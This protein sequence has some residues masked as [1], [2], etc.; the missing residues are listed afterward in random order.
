M[1]KGVMVLVLLLTLFSSML[2]PL[3]LAGVEV[4]EDNLKLHSREDS[5]QL[6]DAKGLR[7]YFANY[8][9]VVLVTGDVIHLYTLANGSSR[10][11]VEPVDPSKTGK[12]FKVFEYRDGLYVIPSDITLDKFDIELF[13][14]KLLAEQIWMTGLNDS[15][16]VIVKPAKGISP[17]QL[18]NTVASID[19]EVKAEHRAK[20]IHKALNLLSIIIDVR[21]PEKVKALLDRLSPSIEKIWLDRIRKI[22]S[23]SFKPLL[24]VS[25]PMIGADWAWVNARATGEGVTIAVLD[26][27]ID[28]SH[29]DFTY[30]N[31]TSKILRAESFVDWPPEEV[32]NPWDYHGHGTH[33]SGI[34]AGTGLTEF[35][36]SNILSLVAHPL[37][38][39]S[40]MDEASIIAGNNTHLAVVWHSDVS[41]NWDIWF[42]I[43]DGEKWST[44]L[45]LTTDPKVDRWP[46]V[47]LLTGNRILVIWGSNRTGQYELWYKVF[48]DG[49]WTE[50]RQLTTDP[51]NYDYLPAF[52]EL[53]DGK[54][55]IIW[56]SEAVGS[57]TSNIF[58]AKLNMAADGTLS[59]ID[60][61]IRQLTN[62]PL[63]S[64][65]IAR[66]LVLT[67]LGKLYAFWD[68]LSHYN[69]ET[70]WGG[71][72]TMYY[73]V[74]TDFGNAWTGYTLASCSGCIS[75]YGIELNNGT[76]IVVFSRDDFE[77]NVP[78]TTYFMK[79]IDG[80]WAGPYWLPIDI[81]HR[82]RPSLAYGPGG[83]YLAATAWSGDNDIIIVPPKPRYM[84]VAPKANLLEAKVLNM[85]GWGFDDWIIAGIEWAVW[86]GA[87]IISMSLGGPPTDGRDPL[88]QAVN[89]A[90][91]Q[92]VLVVV[93]A[94][95][96]GKY[97]G[98]STPGAAEKALTVGAVDDNDKI[99]WFSSRGPTLDFRVKPE[100][101]APGV[102]IC[103]SVPEYIYGKPYDCWSGTSM[104][105]PHVAGAAAVLQSF[106]LSMGWG[107]MQP[108]FLKEALIAEST[109]DL[110]YDV[111]TQGAGRIN[112][113]KELSRI[114]NGYGGTS[115]NPYVINFGVRAIGEEAS[116]NITICEWNINRTFTL[117]VTAKDILTGE[118]RTVASV[119]PQTLTVEK[120]ACKNVTLRISS[121]APAGLYSGKI[122]I[123]DNYG[124]TYN[125]IFGV[126]LAI[127][128][129][130]HKIPW[131]GPENEW[132]VE[133]DLIEA[134]ILNPDSVTE[135]WIGW[136]WSSF[137][138][139]GNAYFMLPE[140]NYQIITVGEYMYKPVFLTYD[141]LTLNTSMSLTFDERNS[142]EV[143]FDPAK[144]GQVFAEVYHAITSE[145]I[146]PP[147][148]YYC[149]DF[150]LSSLEYYPQEVSVY[151]SYS[152][153]MWSIDRYVYYPVEDLNPSDPSIISTGTWHDLVYVEKN[154]NSSR[155]RIPDY[156][157]LVTKNTEY[158]TSAVSRQSAERI[159][160][161]YAVNTFVWRQN[162]PYSRVEIVSPY[163]YYYGFY[164]K[165]RDLPG[166]VTPYWEY[167]GWVLT[168]GSG[169][170]EREVWGEQ[171]LFPTVKSVYADSRGNGTY[172]IWIG[173]ETFTDSNY[174]Y[175]PWFHSRYPLDLIEV[176]VF[177]DGVEIPIDRLYVYYRYW[178]DYY[179]ALFNQ[180][181]P[182][183]YVL[184]TWAFEDQSLST[185]TLLEYEFNLNSD[186]S[187]SGAPVVTNVDVKGLTLNNTLEKPAVHIEFTLH[188]Y[189]NIQ[190]LTFEYS[191]D[192][193]ETWTQTPVE[194][195]GPNSYKTLFTVY[196]GQ[197]YVSIRINATDVSNLKTSITTLNGFL[198][199]GALTLGSFPEPF[200]SQYV[201]GNVIL[202]PG[203]SD[204]R[205]PVDPAHTVDVA[206]SNYISFLF[207][208]RSITGRIVAYMDWEV[209]S[210]NA[211]RV[212]GIWRNGNVITFGSP[213]VNLISYYLHHHPDNN[214]GPVIPAYF[215]VDELGQYIYSTKTGNKYRM[216][217]D[218]GMGR[219]VID[220]ALVTLYY[221][222]RDDRYI[223]MLAGLSGVTTREI[224]RWLSTGV[225]LSGQAM[226]LKFTDNEGDFQP[227]EIEI[228]E[229]IG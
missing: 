103:S 131:E 75:P 101:V 4:G 16:R 202:T 207:G 9:R 11:A 212:H 26:T 167:F 89:W 218:Y 43:Y 49:Q 48:I 206:A 227:D 70:H 99:A 198:V 174:R 149:Y 159:I 228:M 158:R 114:I 94:G 22:D 38:R 188:N 151:Y 62:A 112:L 41:G 208:R 189:T 196:G 61:S 64:W 139:Y 134:V 161:T 104:S 78:D 222:V 102:N 106:A 123:R 124:Y 225:Q 25:V 2:L 135:L 63:N 107:K 177:R 181:S 47:T 173:A 165:F 21:Q 119:S 195:I 216:E 128:L 133:G 126:Y 214:W 80:E 145:M 199:K 162:I 60:G 7:E 175:M 58:F 24:D 129:H 220:Y 144:S 125:I 91:D 163:T 93:A 36:N 122:L 72:T 77:H 190:S 169:S 141:N 204:R 53:P 171:P 143:S 142:Y 69:F 1:L 223:M 68:D 95:N 76:L 45:Q 5:Y 33:V 148:I 23:S 110:G 51:A 66:S 19:K 217:N 205:G 170:V 178:G 34:A 146:C 187:I 73:N 50:D 17:Q 3:T 118:V 31:G 65:L 10:V 52:T 209:A 42:T 13:N 88:S 71:I 86:N 176:K 44:P 98:I 37:I 152:D 109:D 155:T 172:D 157:Q 154:I 213:G 12:D 96:Y 32:G 79:L 127:P 138:K 215:G 111:Y 30:I 90:F 115:F 179:L 29:R 201:L 14:V 39:R 160:W 150:Y 108:Y 15:L 87:D 164:K 8:S 55:G 221:D 54:I 210:F 84:G 140:G 27:G 59:F 168:G 130:V 20:I 192:G 229:I 197:R 153:I 219:K 40:G 183:K 121:S 81:W 185:E 74:S 97:F 191:L 180:T 193:G 136:Q 57:N 92:G 186:G 203:A 46:Y 156:A 35:I 132:A 137:D 194:V 166:R 28:L 85:Y 82:W 226:I 147:S 100:I 182:A 56:S 6:A 184:K 83:L 116:Q 117:E 200:I 67:S 18:I 224:C 113:R 120:G 105:T 211:S